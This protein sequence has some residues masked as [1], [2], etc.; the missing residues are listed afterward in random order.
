MI[1]FVTSGGN[2]QKKN[3]Y[4][5]KIEKKGGRWII[6][7]KIMPCSIGGYVKA[8][9]EIGVMLEISIIYF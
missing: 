1:Y 9:E 2:Q 6:A 3:V 7:H 8:I 4:F 5:W